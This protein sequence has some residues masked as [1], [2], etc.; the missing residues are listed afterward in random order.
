MGALG[1]YKQ[2]QFK[3][4]V[5]TRLGMCST[6]C[7]IVIIWKWTLSFWNY[8]LLASFQL[9]RC[10]KLHRVARLSICLWSYSYW[11]WKVKWRLSRSLNLWHKFNIRQIKFE[12][13]ISRVIL[14]GV[15]SI[16][17][18]GIN[19]IYNYPKLLHLELK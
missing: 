3:L 4:N 12:M 13:F 5:K 17:I 8:L 1:V 2:L 16:T 6:N 9:L 19:C 15:Y 11:L 14:H 7:N 18:L 10:W